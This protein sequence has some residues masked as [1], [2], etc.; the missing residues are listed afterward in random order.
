MDQFEVSGGA[1]KAFKKASQAVN[2]KAIKSLS[3]KVSPKNIKKITN[4]PQPSMVKKI[5]GKS[6]RGAKAVVGKS[7]EGAKTVVGKSVK[8]AKTF[9]S[10]VF[11]ADEVSNNRSIILFR[12]FMA[13]IYFA[14]GIFVY[15]E[16]FYKYFKYL[17]DS[18]CK[19][20]TKDWKYYTLRFYFMYVLALYI[21]NFISILFSLNDPRSFASYILDDVSQSR[22]A[23]FNL[24]LSIFMIIVPNFYIQDLYSNDCECSEHV[25]RDI[26][27]IVYM[28]ALLLYAFIGLKV[29]VY[30]ISTL[31]AN[32]SRFIM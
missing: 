17:E 18:H 16:I 10:T 11:V 28:V 27:E 20:A 15:Y 1:K 5:V 12:L 22:F 3:N 2:K 30:V 31:L 26:F 4:K 29:V 19:C 14:A 6:V 21:A 25:N 8:G 24:I 13:S 7:V 9:A 23:Q 32:V